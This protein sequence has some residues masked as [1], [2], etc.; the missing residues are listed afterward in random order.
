MLILQENDPFHFGTVGR[1]VFTVLRLETAD[2]WDQILYIN[3]YGCDQVNIPGRPYG[4]GRALESIS[5]AAA[6]PRCEP[7]KL[8]QYRVDEARRRAGRP[9]SVGE[10]DKGRV[11]PRKPELEGG[12]RAAHPRRSGGSAV[13]LGR[14][15]R[16]HP[17]VVEGQGCAVLDQVVQEA[18]DPARHVGR[19][20]E[21]EVEAEDLWVVE[22]AR[23]E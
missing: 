17:K 3:L 22:V 21:T 13:R 8:L 19:V 10:L 9:G 5:F 14:P 18:R 2:S 4:L 20:E 6:S 1:S 7:L 12:F 11:Q 15:G 23:V 16:A